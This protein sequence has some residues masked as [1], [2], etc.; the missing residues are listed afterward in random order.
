MIE[1]IYGIRVSSFIINASIYFITIIPSYV[2][3]YETNRIG[4]W[5][6]LLIENVVTYYLF[7]DIDLFE[8]LQQEAKPKEVTVLLISMLISL[9]MFVWIF[10]KHKKLFL[11][12][13]VVELIYL[14][15]T[16]LVKRKS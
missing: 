3:L 4:F 13:I 2:L 7:N 11:I 1:K 6:I 16:K 9:G 10:I 15:I 8:S 14:V 5:L 12:I